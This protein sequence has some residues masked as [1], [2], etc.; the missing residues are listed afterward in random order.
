M[1]LEELVTGW[2]NDPDLD[3]ELAHLERIKAHGAIFG[4]LDP[5]LPAELADRL[6][7]LGIERL[8]RHQAKAISDIRKGLN[9]VVVA[10]TSSGKTLCYTIPIAERI[11]KQPKSTALL[12]YPTKALAQ[13][14]LRSF[15]NL[16]ID[17][18]VAATYDG[19]TE[20]DQR[21]WVR[22]NANVILTNPD[23][24]HLGILPN[25]AKWSDFF[26]RLKYVVVDEMHMFRGIFGSHVALILRRLRRLS[27]HYGANPI[28]IFTSATIGNPVD[29]ATKLSGLEVSLRD[30]DDSPSGEKLIALWNPPIE[31]E[32]QG[33]RRSAMAETSD[34]FVDLVR[35]DHH[36]IVFSRSRKATELI[37][38]WSRDRLDPARKDRIAPYRA[39]YTAESRR[40]TE[41]AL[42]S[43]DLLGITATNALELG[44]DVGSLDA[45]IINTF[46]GTISSFRQQA[47]R[48]G[49]TQRASVAVLVGGEDALDQYFMNHPRELFDRTPESVVVNPS[50]PLVLQAHV[51]CAAH[52]LPLKPSDAELLGDDTEEAATALVAEGHLE[53]RR[54]RLMW[55]HQQPPAPRIS[56]RSSGGPTYTITSDEGLLGTMEETRA[57]TDAHPDAVYLHQGDTYVVEELDLRRHEIRVRSGKVNYYTQAKSEKL[58]EVLQTFESRPLGQMTQ[59]FGTIRVESQ[60]VGYQKKKI[61]SGETISHEW[62]DLPASVFETQGVWLEIPESLVGDMSTDRLL[63]TLHAAE[64]AGI[65]M[66]PL[67]AVCDRWDIG[68][69][70][71]NWHPDLGG[72]AIFIYE[73]YPGGAGISPVAFEIGADHWAATREAIRSCPCKAG[74]PSCVVSPKCGNFNEPLDKQGAV[75]FLTSALGS[76]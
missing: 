22:K 16:A 61:G 33:R 63:G 47:G 17:D 76:G 12:L 73:A 54:G 1:G 69:L 50:N 75:D 72:P 27:A 3:G 30:Q 7:E 48:A 38:V 56:I 46:P 23:M 28:F 20:I 36:T 8:Y 57:F 34:L 51:A 5:P 66:L 60:V 2:A 26:V 31:D 67:F 58:L 64:H 70:S 49:R 15:G 42:F 13:D 71:T 19:D 74:C 68:G 44:I 59:H 18:L 39:G 37:Y 43:G 14:Q 32:E 65:A 21:Q 29:L 24:L 52:E 53:L 11:L 40:D 45:A 62:L 6:A 4:D 25:H 10:G 35:H 9:T 55:A 41:A